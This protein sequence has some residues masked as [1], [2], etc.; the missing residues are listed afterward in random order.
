[1]RG[2]LLGVVVVL[3]SVGAIERSA[4]AG[5]GGIVVPPLEVDV[6]ATAPVRGGEASGPSMDVLIGLHWASVYWHPTRFEVGFGYVGSV[7]PVDRG[8]RALE[9]M[10]GPVHDD[11]FRLDGG[12]LTLGTTLI[13]Q[14]HFRTWIEARGELLRGRL[15]GTPSFSAIGGAVRFAAELYGGVAGGAGGGNAIGLV[16][17]T[18][19]IGIFVEA[20]HR[21]IANELGATG[22]TT[23]ISFRVPFIL[24]G[25]G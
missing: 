17:G 22:I 14:P 6:G 3:F 5:G 15:P 4:S 19:A 24:I 18:F 9:R 8:Y 7:R 10:P 1:M 25:V 16:A 20:S 21:D 12:Y 13:N 11:T 2:A 23:G